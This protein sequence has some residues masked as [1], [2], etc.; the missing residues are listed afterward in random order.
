MWDEMIK[1]IIWV[2]EDEENSAS[3]T[4]YDVVNGWSVITKIM[5]GLQANRAGRRLVM[6]NLHKSGR[7]TVN[8]SI[9][10]YGLRCENS[11]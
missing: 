2:A 6:G 10:F 1:Q 3:K 9:T 8:T 7:A 4:G 5:I 11:H